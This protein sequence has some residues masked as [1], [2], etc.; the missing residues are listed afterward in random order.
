M[1]DEKRYLVAIQD[2]NTRILDPKYLKL[3]VKKTV[4]QFI[5]PTEKES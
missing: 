2:H 5:V 1:H 4:N 3:I